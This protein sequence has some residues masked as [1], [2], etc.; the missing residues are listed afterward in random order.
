MSTD[1]T[2]PPDVPDSF[3]ARNELRFLLVICF[4][5]VTAVLA[6][7]WLAW[8]Q[9]GR[10]ID[11]D[12]QAPSAPLSI[13]IDLNSANWPE[14]T[15]LPG[16]SEVYA[17]RIVEYRQQHGQFHDH[18]DLLNIRGIGQRKLEKI[19]PHLAPL[20]PTSTDVELP[21]QQGISP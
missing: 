8:Q 13:A 9:H 1:E 15:L 5:L 20:A 11:I 16:I 18:S 10:L 21:S 17:K 6:N 4:V 14:L 7:A 3:L 12:E 2:A 19:I